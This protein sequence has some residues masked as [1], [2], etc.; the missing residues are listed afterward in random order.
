MEVSGVECKFCIQKI[1][2]MFLQS[3]QC[4]NNPHILRAQALFD[5]RFTAMAGQDGIDGTCKGTDVYAAMQAILSE[6]SSD[7]ARVYGMRSLLTDNK[8]SVM[9]ILANPVLRSPVWS[10]NSTWSAV[11]PGNKAIILDGTHGHTQLIAGHWGVQGQ[12]N[13]VIPM[14]A[15]MAEIHDD[16]Q[17]L[18]CWGEIVPAR[19]TLVP[20]NLLRGI[21]QPEGQ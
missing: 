11:N 8:S 3:M 2:H 17:R 9:N 10:T 18:V 1:W 5:A 14:Y 13:V 15:N 20:T 21:M 6:H 7:K 19:M 16:L 4:K 12:S